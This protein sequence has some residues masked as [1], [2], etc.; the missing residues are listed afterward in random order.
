MNLNLTAGL[1]AITA[2]SLAAQTTTVTPPG[3]AT[4][5]GLTGT[6]V[7]PFSFGVGRTQLH[8][9]GDL[10]GIP[11]AAQIQRIGFR[12]DGNPSSNAAESARIIQLEVLMASTTRSGTGVTT[13]YANNYDGTPTTVFATRLFNLPSRPIQSTQPTTEVTYVPLDNPFQFDSSRNLIVDF[14]ITANNN[15]NASFRYTS[16]VAP[17]LT[18]STTYGTA[19]PNSQSTIPALSA[20]EVALG[21]TWSLPLVRGPRSSGAALAIGVGNTSFQGLPLPFDMAPLGAPGCTIHVDVA[22]NLTAF[23]NTSGNFTWNLPTPNNLSLDG[24]SFYA[25][26]FMVDLFANNFGL[27]SSNGVRTQFSV[28]T[29][30]QAVAH[31][32][33]PSR[34]TGT[35]TR[36]Y[37]IVTYFEH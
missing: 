17:H 6:T 7:Q 28:P 16:D 35:V 29:R 33:D 32:G 24:V 30:Q 27:I 26:V 2:A 21:Q 5:E 20:N 4:R 12:Q 8:Y 10:V 22:V 3:L 11:N 31:T 14:I 18:V 23:L 25:Q 15:N 19:C 1:L 13:N 9:Y 37:G 34:A 36:S